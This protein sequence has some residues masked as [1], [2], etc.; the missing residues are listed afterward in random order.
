[1]QINIKLD[2]NFTTQF[3]KLS[4]EY[5]TDM[6][7]LNGFADE[8]LSY[9]DFIDNFVDKQTVADASIDGNSN[10]GTKDVCSLNAEMNK[11]HSKLLA[12]N[13]IYYEM[14]KKYGFKTA[15]SWLESEWDGHHY[16]HDASSS[17]EISYCY[18]YD[19]E[20]LATKGLYF[21]SNFNAQPPKHLVTFTDFVGEFVSWNSNRTAGAVGLPSFLI[22]S[23]YFWNRDKNNGYYTGTPEKYRDQEFQRIIYK[24]NQP[25]LRV[26]QSAFTNFSIFDTSYLTALFGDKTFPD[27]S[28]IIDYVDEILEYQKSFMKVCSEIRSNNM[29]TF[30]VLSFSLLKK[31]G[32]FVD[33]DFAKWCCKHNM[34]W[35]DS[36]FFVSDDITSLSNCCFDGKQMCLVK[37][38][39]NEVLHTSFSDLYHHYDP[40]ENFQIYYNG[41][42]ANGK[43]VQLNLKRTPKLEMYKIRT[44]NNKELYVTDNHIFPTLDGVKQVKDLTDEDYLMFNLQ[45][46]QFCTEKDKGLTYVQGVDLGR[47]LAGD[48][49]EICGLLKRYVFDDY[50]EGEELSAKCLLQSYDFR[51]GILDGLC[52]PNVYHTTYTTSET[53]AQRIEILINSL[54]MNSKITVKDQ[55]NYKDYPVRTYCIHWYSPTCKLN[56]RIGLKDKYH[57]YFK[58]D[59]IEKYKP[60]SEYVYCFEMKNRYEPYFTLPNGVVTHNCRLV[61]DVK[62]LGYF[63]SV[64][65]T[66]LEVGSVKVNTINL[67]RLAYENPL[68]KDYLK[69]LKENVT[70]CLKALDVI[71]H[72]IVRNVEKGLLPN[73]TH[74]LIDINSQYNTIG[75]IGI[76]ETLQKYGMTYKDELGYTYYTEEGIEFAKEILKTINDTKDKFIC[77][78][79]I[80]IEQ[81]PGERAA[82]ILMQKD[83][84]FYP[85]ETYELPLYGNQWIPLGVKTSLDEKIKLSATL[86]KACNGGSIAHINI[87]SPFSNFETA[88]DMLNKVSDAGVV[89]F[90]FCTKIS[91]CENNHGFY[92]E[93]CP[94]CGKPKTT[95]YQRIVGFLTPEKTY[96][97]E[98]KDEF[99]LRDWFDV[100]GTE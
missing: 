45:P 95:T 88:W 82:S 49:K 15:N 80:N 93:T 36:N 79:S 73:Y 70:L 75:I 89:Y 90:A 11:P 53:N 87:E 91:A 32:K 56:K 84:F 85:N 17:S 43:L 10:A 52:H 38:K 29:M 13:K 77:D 20:D 7:R 30:P 44:T 69:A 6:A 21:I 68:R 3:N 42:W 12:F 35:A 28:Y 31:D 96:S 64:G 76:Y 41:G 57:H 86:D 100:N 83:K 46:L 81:I 26:N 33:E 63:N 65:G 16:L 8:Q 99:Q 18:A 97:Q 40:N 5:G 19:L 14:N 4:N 22:Y 34:K 71:R 72:I 60:D 94:T 39:D 1:M 59:T 55:Y 58:I 27:G 25:Y 98:R 48:K 61:S 23:F 24:L 51:Q 62:N 66:A 67:A 37:T 92:G 54:G 47:Y 2:K 78:Y 50:T 9:T 74:G